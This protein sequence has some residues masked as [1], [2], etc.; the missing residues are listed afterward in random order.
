MKRCSPSPRSE[1]SSSENTAPNSVEKKKRKLETKVGTNDSKSAENTKEST[2][3]DRKQK[4]ESSDSSSDEFIR[5]PPLSDFDLSRFP[6]KKELPDFTAIEKNILTG[7]TRLSDSEDSDFDGDLKIKSNYSPRVKHEENE[8]DSTKTVKKKKA[9]NNNTSRIKS[10]KRIPSTGSLGVANDR[11]KVLSAPDVN[12][13]DVSQLLALGEVSGTVPEIH[14]TVTKRA[15]SLTSDSDND[16][17]DWED[18]EGLDVKPTEHIIPKEG[19]EVTLQMPDI[20][21]KQKKKGFDMEA[22]V[23]R[24][25]N[26][27]KCELQVLIHKVHLLCWIA[28]GRFINSVLNSEVLM[29]Q[30]LSLIPSQHCY[31]SKHTNLRYLEQIVEWF[32]K[33]VTVSDE[34]ENRPLLPLFESLQQAFQLRT[35]HSTRDLVLMF[36]CILRTLGVKARLMISLQPVPLKPSS[37]ELCS[38]NKTRE[39]KKSDPKEEV[40]VVKVENTDT[41]GPS[42]ATTS[43]KSLKDGK[44]CLKG[45]KSESTSKILVEKPVN[46]KYKNSNE[47][48]S[49]SNLKS[50]SQDDKPGE[51]SRNDAD[52]SIGKSD[53]L[54]RSLRT[55]KDIM[56]I[57]KERSDSSDEGDKLN[58]KTRVIDRKKQSPKTRVSNDGHPYK[59]STDNVRVIKL[60]ESSSNK[61][62]KT[63]T[64]KRTRGNSS[65]AA[66]SIKRVANSDSDSDFVP[67]SLSS[68]KSCDFKRTATTDSNSESDF[69]PK[70]VKQRKKSTNETILDRKVTASHSSTS[71][72]GKGTQKKKKKNCDVWTEVFVE[73]EEKWISVDVQHGKLHCVAELHVSYPFLFVILVSCTSKNVSVGLHGSNAMWTWQ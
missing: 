1:V 32:K 15:H 8:R 33:T 41:R 40:T 21:R 25:L 56:N 5:A 45:K 27:V 64:V 19:I 49:N 59:Q 50:K 12:K 55:R 71:V 42:H 2:T 13:M 57:Y 70:K 54:K 37:Q 9:L 17:S 47:I 10:E 36:I 38:I 58:Q 62:I 68:Q 24:R 44:K 67:E 3:H 61:G 73:E 48:S 35:A 34:T 16:L 51:K 20:H 63:V 69:E 72:A 14:T 28:H 30:S 46:D 52:I 18:V 65:Q 23:R 66:S 60:K 39:K 7:V 31:P 11:M 43:K 29:A 22:H 6:V 4:V 26:R 53:K